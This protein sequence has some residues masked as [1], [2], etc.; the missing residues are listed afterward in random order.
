M[1][2]I[3]SPFQALRL[4]HLGQ[5]ILARAGAYAAAGL[6]D[7][8]FA[9]DA[10]HV[11]QPVAI[12]AAAP[13]AELRV[14]SLGAMEVLVAEQAAAAEVW[15][16]ARPKE[17][18]VYLLCHPEGSTR[19]QVGV[20]FWP[21]ASSSQVKN[22]FHV[23][24]HKLRKGLGRADRIVLQADRYR[25][26][27]AVD[28]WFD[29]VVFERDITSALATRSSDQLEAAVAHYR[30]DFLDGEAVGD[31][32]LDV[33]A[34]LRD[35]YITGLSALADLHIRRDE[36]RKASDTL[37]LLVQHE[38]LQEDAYRRLMLCLARTGQR[39][40]ALRHYHR[41]VTLLNDELDAEPE[42]VAEQLA[43]RI[44]ASVAV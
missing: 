17:L 16:H 21:D 6:A 8:V 7:G 20:A 40:R 33:R 30:C 11:T 25:V 23:L 2:R 31:W 34:R 38:N 3:R 10:A 12:A 28:V 18:L 13:Q 15:S 24:L 27:P 5:R 37:E 43:E 35:L 39:D 22:S 19:E 4:L 14:R 36:L 41:L 44:R 1:R 32:H 29:A 42:P 9:T 26:N